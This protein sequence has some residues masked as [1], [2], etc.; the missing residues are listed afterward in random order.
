[1]KIPILSSFDVNWFS[2]VKYKINGSICASSVA[3]ACL[4]KRLS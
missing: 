4:F 2:V 1:M 3:F